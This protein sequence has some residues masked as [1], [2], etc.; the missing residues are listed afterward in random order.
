MPPTVIELALPLTTLPVNVP[1]PPISRPTLLVPTA[2]LAPVPVTWIVPLLVI[3]PES[4]PPGVT[5]ATPVPFD[6]VVVF[7][8]REAFTVTLLLESTVI[9]VPL[10]TSTVPSTM[11]LPGPLFAFDVVIA[12]LRV[13]VTV[14]SAAVAGPAA[15]AIRETPVQMLAMK[16]EVTR[17]VFMG[18]FQ[19]LPAAPR[20][21]SSPPHSGHRNA[22][23]YRLPGALKRLVADRAKPCR[24]QWSGPCP[25][26]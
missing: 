2:S 24:R 23:R 26:T 5:T 21:T 17:D 19:I 13:P 6:C 15:S 12:V 16:D 22:A 14:R 7:T 25:P 3:V 1:V 20:M 11:T 8:V 10:E 4:P 9:A 18:P